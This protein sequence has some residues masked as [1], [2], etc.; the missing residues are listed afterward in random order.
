MQTWIASGWVHLAIGFALGW[1]VFKRPEWAAKLV[2]KAKAK[3]K[4]WE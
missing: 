4:F 2:E 3:L 1:L